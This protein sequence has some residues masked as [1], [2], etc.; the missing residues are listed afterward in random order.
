MQKR[1]HF[2]VFLQC[3]IHVNAPKKRMGRMERK[4]VHVFPRFPVEQAFIFITHDVISLVVDEMDDLAR[5]EGN[6]VVSILVT[7]EIALGG[8]EVGACRVR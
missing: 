1:S 4:L 6:K 7:F 8:Y 2:P 3:C 5:G